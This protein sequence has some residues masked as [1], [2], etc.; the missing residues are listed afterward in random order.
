M[1]LISGLVWHFQFVMLMLSV[2]LCGL[3]S[4][5]MMKNKTKA[6]KVQPPRVLRGELQTT[7]LPSYQSRGCLDLAITQ[8]RV[9]D[10]V[11]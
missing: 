4:M 2:P 11:F 7:Q 3:Q 9:N 10:L 1:R 5:E 8:H 6:Q